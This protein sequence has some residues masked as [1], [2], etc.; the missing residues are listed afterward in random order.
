ME[1]SLCATPLVYEIRTKNKVIFLDPPI[2]S[3]CSNWQ[4]LEH[5]LIKTSSTAQAVAFITFVQDLK[6]KV[7]KWEPEIKIF[8]KD[9]L[10][11]NQIEGEWTVFNELLKQK[12]LT[13]QDQ[14][15]RLQMKIVAEDKVV[16]SKIKTLL[17]DWEKEKPISRELQPDIAINPINLFETRVN[18]L[19]EEKRRF[20]QKSVALVGGL[21][22]DALRERHWKMIYKNLRLSGHYSP[23]QMTL[24]TIW[25]MDLKKNESLIR[26][27]LAQATGEVALEEYIKQQVFKSPYVLD[28]LQIPEVLKTLDKLVESLSKLQKAL[29]EYLERERS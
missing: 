2:E 16:R 17:N 3:A 23:S 4:D 22:S 7:K 26:Q 13:I 11:V 19:Q 10:Y 29:G 12:N 1:N 28:V 15:A 6:R 18:R 20:H 21:K 5:H 24:G 27:V 14:L 9:W 25:D 8:G